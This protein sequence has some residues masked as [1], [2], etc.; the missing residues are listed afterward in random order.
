MTTINTNSIYCLSDSVVA[1][2]IEGEIIIIPLSASIGD[3][4]DELYTLNESAKNIWDLI[5]DGQTVENIISKLVREYSTG[6]DEI[7]EDVVGLVSE[8]VK[9]NIIIERAT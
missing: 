1:R 3:M 7:K 5:V 4:E 2:E 6:G 9:R 8:L